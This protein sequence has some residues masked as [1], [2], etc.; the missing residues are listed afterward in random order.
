MLAKYEIIE[1]FIIMSESLN[2]LETTNVARSWWV[3]SSKQSKFMG[4]IKIFLLK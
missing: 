2:L 1:Y 3:R 4:E